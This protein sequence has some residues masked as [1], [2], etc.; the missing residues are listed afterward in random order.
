MSLVRF[1]PEAPCADLAHLV[2][3]HL[4][5]VEVAGSSPVIRSK[6]K[7]VLAIARAFFFLERPTGSLNPAGSDNQA[8]RICK[9]A[10][11]CA[12]ADCSAS[13]SSLTKRGA[14]RQSVSRFAR[15]EYARNPY[16]YVKA[17]YPC[18]RLVFILTFVFYYI[19]I[20]LSRLLIV[21]LAPDYTYKS[22][23]I[24]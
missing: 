16:Y 23:F 24:C 6:K 1:R 18:F 11:K 21:F 3:R 7:N 17:F 9:L 15:K 12:S 22:G 5:K 14:K 8:K 20:I 2:E 4:A 13:A 10:C 19:C